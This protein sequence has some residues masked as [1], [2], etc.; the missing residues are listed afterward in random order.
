MDQR[1]AD[2]LA[3]KT[4]E[5][6]KILGELDVIERKERRR[7]NQRRYLLRNRKKISLRASERWKKKHPVTI[8]SGRWRKP[9]PVINDRGERFLSTQEAGKA[10][11]VSKEA[12]I[13]AIQNPNRISC[14]KRWAYEKH[15]V[16]AEWMFPADFSKP[17][18]GSVRHK[19]EQR[20]QRQ[21]KRKT[22]EPIAN[23]RC[24]ADMLG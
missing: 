21:P 12:I 2:F 13:A 10:H 16:P 3:K 4:I 9:E 7:K 19:N 18:P 23:H 6:H 11:G 22:L 24:N 1:R 17:F 14:G 15:G 8:G 20:H 5:V